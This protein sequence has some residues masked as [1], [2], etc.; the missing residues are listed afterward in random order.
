MGKVSSKDTNPKNRKR[1]RGSSHKYLKPGT[2]AQLRDTKSI[3]AKSCTD[4]GRKRVVVSESQE[5]DTDLVVG[6]KAIDKSPLMLSPVNLVKQS[7]LLLTPKTPRPGDCESESRLE[8]LPMD[9]L[10]FTVRLCLE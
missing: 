4:I 7:N 8:S 2:L 6:D 3:G 1:L 5:A 10:V 9:L